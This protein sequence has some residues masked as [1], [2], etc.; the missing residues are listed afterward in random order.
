MRITK[1]RS[2]WE[3]IANEG[4]IFLLRRNKRFFGWIYVL[5]QCRA[6]QQDDKGCG[7]REQVADYPM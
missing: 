7:E 4:G 6:A 3:V 2:R 5:R 1:Q